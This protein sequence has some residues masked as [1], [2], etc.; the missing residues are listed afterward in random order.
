MTQ[1]LWPLAT[2]TALFLL[3]AG[4]AKSAT[5]EAKS[6]ALADVKS[7]IASAG[8]G[9]TVTV[10]AGT[11]SW[12]STLTITKGITLKGATTIDGSLSSPE[13][14]DGTI[15]LDDVPRQRHDGPGRKQQRDVPQQGSAAG[16]KP[17]FRGQ[18]RAASG[19]NAAGG[20]PMGRMPAIVRATL[21]PDQS[22]RLTGFTFKY[23]SVTT[24]ADN[25]GVH[26]M[27]TCPS[28]RI[29][30]CHFDQLYANPFIMTRGQIYGVVD[31]CVFDERGRALTFQ[32]YHDGWGG[33]TH[34]DGSWADATPILEA[35]SSCSLKTTPSATLM[36]IKAMALIRMVVVDMSHGTITWLILR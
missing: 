18:A 36:A 16:G 9:D 8:E 21:K 25:G 24:F 27:G 19:P 31:H 12:A 23:G 22:F 20:P 1:P 3:A 6:A 28:A 13:V 29:D 32:I 2:F 7:A 30:H 35:R 26:L 4:H 17:S 5:V 33:H 15:I 34:G 11:A 14:T 10:P